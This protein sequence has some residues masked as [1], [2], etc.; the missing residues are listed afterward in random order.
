M[1]RKANVN[2][3]MMRIRDLAIGECTAFSDR[4]LMNQVFDKAEISSRLQALRDRISPAIRRAAIIDEKYRQESGYF[5]TDDFRTVV[6]VL[7][8]WRVS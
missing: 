2:G 1:P 3:P 4:V 8:V 7:N 5:V 6:C